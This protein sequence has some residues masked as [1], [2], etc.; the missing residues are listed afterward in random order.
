MKVKDLLEVK[1]P[2]MDDFEEKVMYSISRSIRKDD[3]D[4]ALQKAL[5]DHVL[6]FHAKKA[7]MTPKQ[8]E[9]K[10]KKIVK[11]VWRDIDKATVVKE[12]SV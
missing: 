6:D 1:V 3:P 4:G 7:G 2:R 5:N 11:T 8:R 12:P 10:I 9:N